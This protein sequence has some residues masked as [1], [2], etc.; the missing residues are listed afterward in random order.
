[1]TIDLDSYQRQRDHDR[2]PGGRYVGPE[3]PRAEMAAACEDEEPPVAPGA[4]LAI[5]VVAPAIAC[6]GLLLIGVAIGIFAGLAL[7]ELWP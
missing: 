1:M 3:W 5:P 2:R 6:W 4:P 7:S